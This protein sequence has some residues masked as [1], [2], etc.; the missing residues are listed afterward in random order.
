MGQSVVN[1]FCSVQGSVYSHTF[2]LVSSKNPHKN[3][4]EWYGFYCSDTNEVI[5][6]L[7]CV[8]LHK[9][10]QLL[11]CLVSC[12]AEICCSTRKARWLCRERKSHRTGGRNRG[13]LGIGQREKWIVVK[14]SETRIQGRKGRLNTW[15]G[16]ECPKRHVLYYVHVDVPS[17]GLVPMEHLLKSNYF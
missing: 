12:F 15:S 9:L 11:P 16:D 8:L 6:G 5:C 10:L 4:W 13:H 7:W 1:I 3:K 2:L 17:L 14:W